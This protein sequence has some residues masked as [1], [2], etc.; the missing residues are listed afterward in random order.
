MTTATAIRLTGTEACV[1]EPPPLRALALARCLVRYLSLRDV[2]ERVPSRP[3]DARRRLRTKGCAMSNVD[4]SWRPQPS[5][6]AL[7][8]VKAW[9]GGSDEQMAL[10]LDTW[11]H[12]GSLTEPAPMPDG[13]TAVEAKCST[14]GGQRIVSVSWPSGYPHVA[15][16]PECRPGAPC[17]CGG[18]PGCPTPDALRVWA[19]SKP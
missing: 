4:R 10:A 13:A 8:F 12:Q 9:R 14:C 7:A 3:G 18:V 15:P 11:R 1:R 17:E 19:A 6:E 2:Q 5:A 16:C